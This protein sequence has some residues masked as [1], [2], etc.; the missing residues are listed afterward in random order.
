MNNYLRGSEWSKWD[1]HIHTPYSINQQYGGPEKFDKYIEALERLP[2][3]VK[4]IGITDYYFIDGYEKVMEYKVGGRLKNIEKIFPILEFR[5]DTFGSGS[6]NKLQKINLHILFN[7]DEANLDREIRKVK[8]EFI[9]QIPLTRLDQHRTKCVSI[10]NFTSECGD[11]Q[12]GFSSL[13]PSTKSVFEIINSPTWKDKTFLFLGYK[14]WSNLEKNQQLRPFKQDLYNKVDAFLTSSLESMDRSQEWLNEYGDKRLLYSGDIHSFDFLDTAEKDIKDNYIISQNYTC[15]TWIKANPTFEGL[16]QIIYEPEYRVCI[17][18]NKPEIKAGYHIIESI[19]LNEDNFWKQKVLFNQNLNTIIGGRSTGKSTLL[20]CIAKEVAVIDDKN[21]FIDQHLK[22][23]AVN[24]K[25]QENVVHDIDYFPQSY[26]YELAKDKDQTDELI[27]KIIEEKDQN[28]S[29]K[30]YRDFSDNNRGDISGKV[31]TIFKL[32]NDLNKRFSELK[33]K[34]VKSGILKEIKSLEQ[35]LL[36]MKA[37]DVTENILR[38]YE[39]DNESIN[40]LENRLSFIKSDL[41]LLDKLIMFDII[42]TKIEYSLNDL[43]ASS[44]DVIKAVFNN[45]R[46][47]ANDQ[48]IEEI[49]RQIVI[50]NEEQEKIKSKIM[51]IKESEDYLNVLD[52]LKTNSEYKN[53]QNRIAEERKKLME[54]SELENAIEHQ[55]IQ[56]KELFDDIILSHKKY[57]EKANSLCENLCFECGGISINAKCSFRNDELN[58]FLGERLNLRSEER[59]RYVNNITSNYMNNMD[60]IIKNFLIDSLDKKIECKGIY[61]DKNSPSVASDFLAT[62]W[63]KI[64]YVLTYQNDEFADMSQGKQAFVI[65]KLLLDFSDKKCPILIDQPEDSLDN[66]AIYNELVEYLKE[67]KRERQIILVTHNANVVVGADAEQIIIANQ[68]GKDS[69]NINDLRFQ[70][71]SGGLENTK[72]KDSS[73]ECI[74]DCQGIREHVCEVLEGGDDAFIKRE[75][76]YNLS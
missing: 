17:Q 4:V 24:W 11:L 61:A 26:M 30:N 46:Q 64:S 52:Y 15:N 50:I 3:N 6:E 33:E 9:T 32:Q 31:N 66:R 13:I 59:R 27:E 16:K 1:L 37:T 18:N 22:G 70:Y 41:D 47:Q 57:C 35:V 62:N 7:I 14:E 69:K 34:G 12:A 45:V 8:D 42:S 58:D 73:I 25:D 5:I 39:K 63:C 19:D 21:V 51:E 55:K 75:Q 44:R 76:K 60:E 40:T 72:K 74:L 29:L 54:I 2:E 20:G 36:N 71:V 67:K 10:A 65:L 38:K 43:S 68:H 56:R 53:I 49:S 28:D 23:V 48:W